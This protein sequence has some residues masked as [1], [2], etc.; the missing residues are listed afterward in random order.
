MS[1]NEFDPVEW[2]ASLDPLRD[3]EQWND[4]RRDPEAL[5]LYRRVNAEIGAAARRRR[6][7]VGVVA[8]A[9]VLAATGAGYLATRQPT[10]P[11][12]VACYSEFDR[13]SSAV[14]VPHHPSPLETCRRAWFSSEFD[15]ALPGEQSP[16]LLGCVLDSGM[17]A[18]FP[19]SGNQGC[20]DLGLATL[21]DHRVDDRVQEF[22]EELSS[23]LRSRCVPPQEARELAQ[24][25]LDA[26]DLVGWTARIS[27]DDAPAQ[28]CASLAVDAPS[29]VVLIVPIPP[30]PNP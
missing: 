28:W 18:V 17:A 13:S 21:A 12:G 20:S 23:E 15:E 8:A 5:E 3:E 24:D 19:R 29:R 26:L 6:V 27:R 10:D 9:I 7:L 22:I 30:A 11:T 1:D 16:P 25:E 4:V 2:L 14:V